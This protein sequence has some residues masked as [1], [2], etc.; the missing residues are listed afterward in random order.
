M[1]SFLCG[2]THF[3]RAD[4]LSQL[5]VDSDGSHLEIS[6]LKGPFSI[7]ALEG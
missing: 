3:S 1:N 7:V 2:G 6:W 4:F 5:A